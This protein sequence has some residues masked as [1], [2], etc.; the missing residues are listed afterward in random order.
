MYAAAVQTIAQAPVLER[1]AEHVVEDARGVVE[2][3]LL[4]VPPVAPAVVLAVALEDAR[5]VVQAH[6][7]ALVRVHVLTHVRVVLEDV[8]AIAQEHV[9][10]HAQELVLLHVSVGIIINLY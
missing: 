4:H 9:R 10:E 6:V 3:V 2:D 1:V 5:V 7:Q 8:W